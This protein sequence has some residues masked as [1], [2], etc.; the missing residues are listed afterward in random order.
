MLVI[1]HCFRPLLP[2]GIVDK[3]KH[4]PL[5]INTDSVNRKEV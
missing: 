5:G 1:I 4:F 3:R 2:A